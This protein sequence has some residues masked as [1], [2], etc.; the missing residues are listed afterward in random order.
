MMWSRKIPAKGG[1]DPAFGYRA[2]PTRWSFPPFG[3]GERTK[4]ESKSD[5]FEISN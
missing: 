5:Q 2:F 1:N 4:T 3:C